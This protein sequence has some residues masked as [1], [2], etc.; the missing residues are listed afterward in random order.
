MFVGFV[1]DV[2][3]VWGIGLVAH[4]GHAKTTTRDIE[5]GTDND[6]HHT[7]THNGGKHHTG[8]HHAGTAHTAHAGTTAT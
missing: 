3:I 1:G 2:A 7:G 6:T 8:T 4:S 5:L